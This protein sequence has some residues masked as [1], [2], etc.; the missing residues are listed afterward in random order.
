MEWIAK[1][2]DENTEFYSGYLEPGFPKILLVSRK[3]KELKESEKEF[4]S[5]L[6]EVMSD[7]TLFIDSL[8]YADMLRALQYIN[9][10]YITPFRFILGVIK[11]EEEEHTKPEVI[12]QVHRK[13]KMPIA[14]IDKPGCVK[15]KFKNELGIA[16]LMAI[17]FSS[18]FTSPVRR[19]GEIKQVISQL[20]LYLASRREEFV[21]M[22]SLVVEDTYRWY[23]E[24]VNEVGE[25]M[26]SELRYLAAQLKKV[27]SLDEKVEGIKKLK[28]ETK[29]PEV[30]E[31]FMAI[32]SGSEFLIGRLKAISNIIK[33]LPEKR[34]DHVLTVATGQWGIAQAALI[35]ELVKANSFDVM[36]TQNSLW[37]RL[38]EEF[39][40]EKVLKGNV[41]V[42]YKVRYH[43]VSATDALI[44][45]KTVNEALNNASRDE[46]LI[47][48]QGPASIAVPLYLLGKKRGITSIM[49]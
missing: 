38:F 5:T 14:V 12:G 22:L 17:A 1:V 42:P 29:F 25:A 35:S 16:K 30:V 4:L 3:G 43:P 21:E 34:F 37:M 8:R 23:Y 10:S 36:Y 44:V 39:C 47:L 46:T 19:G 33:K 28:N 49:L 40:R 45:G 9:N 41:E 7:F 6:L 24:H 2:E 27:E 11:R 32:F 48:A 20:L 31:K 15:Y 26:A 13:L 18:L